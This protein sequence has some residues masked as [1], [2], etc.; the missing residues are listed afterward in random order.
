[1]PEVSLL[2][3]LALMIVFAVVI[4]RIVSS[5]VKTM[6]I[7]SAVVAIMIA[8]AGGVVALDAYRLKERLQSGD[9]VLL[10]AGKD[11]AAISS[12]V[13]IKAAG[14]Q[15]S[16]GFDAL[17]GPELDAINIEL[18]KGG[19]SVL[20]NAI[21]GNPGLVLVINEGAITG[22]IPGDF[23][24]G[25]VPVSMEAVL[26]LLAEG[27]VEDKA[28]LLAAILAANVRQNPLYIIEEYRQGNLRVYP[29]GVAFKAIRLLPLPIFRKVAGKAFD[30]L[31]DGA[32]RIT[33]AA[34]ANLVNYSQGRK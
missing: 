23:E 14:S 1:M 16:Q 8:V 3:V 15:G 25:G 33:S 32:T 34:I 12:G 11:W 24:I 31:S 17:S 5:I 20:P 2:I 27:S 22:A 10:V 13:V 28:M 6:L 4:F 29:E 26:K 18:A 30:K 7:I 21:P 9:S 19:Y